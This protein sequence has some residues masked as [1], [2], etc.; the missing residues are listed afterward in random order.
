ML[1]KRPPVIVIL[2]IINLLVRWPVKNL[3]HLSTEVVFQSKRRKEGEPDTVSPEK[4]PLK[5]R[6]ASGVGVGVTII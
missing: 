4:R 2:L 1:H 3:C 5:R 6:F